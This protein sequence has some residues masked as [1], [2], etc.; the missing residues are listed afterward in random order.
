MLLHI[1]LQT[2]HLLCFIHS[3]LAYL[4]QHQLYRAT[5]SRN[6][7]PSVPHVC[8]WRLRSSHSRAAHCPG[9]PASQLLRKRA[10]TV[11]PGQLTADVRFMVFTL[12][13]AC[14]AMQQGQEKWVWIMDMAGGW[15]GAGTACCAA[16]GLL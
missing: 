10:D 6:A 12:E 14:R 7:F 4:V 13:S 1:R 5:G 2:Q 9:P 15:G 11:A 16:C 3:L 8:P